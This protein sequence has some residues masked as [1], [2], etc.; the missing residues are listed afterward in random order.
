MGHI[1]VIENSLYENIS[2]ALR[3]DQVN[4]ISQVQLTA[5]SKTVLDVIVQGSRGARC[6]TSMLSEVR[7]GEHI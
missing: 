2:D 6:A 5:H 4:P 7:I 1:S 3:N